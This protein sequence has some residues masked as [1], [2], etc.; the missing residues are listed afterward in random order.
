[1]S[2]KSD[3]FLILDFGSQVTQLIARRLRELNYYSEI[4]SYKTP[5]DEIKKM[6]PKGI[7]LSGG[8][9]SVYEAGAPYRSIKELQEI[10][11]LLGICYG[12][13]LICHDLGGE[14]ESAQHRE[15]GYQ[16]IV[17]HNTF[18]DFSSLQK[19]W[20]SHGDVVKKVPKGFEI[21]GTTENHPAVVK[22]P[23][24]L[25]VQFHPEV[26]HTE[27]GN[28]VFKY[29]A[30]M[31]GAIPS[32]NAGSMLATLKEE[33]LKQVGE[34]SHILCALS[35]GVDS[36]VVATLLTQILG[37][38][39]VHC[40]FVNNGL[41][42]KDE[43]ETV[44]RDFEGL[45][46]NIKG[47]DARNEFLSALKGLTDP[48]Q[49]RK[50]IGRVFIEVFEKTIGN[51]NQFQFLAQGT[52]YPDV[53]E[54]V[55]SIGGSVTI[56]SHHNVGGLP[57]KM[58]L[59]LV[60]PVRLLFKDE[61]RRLGLELGLPAKLIQRHPFPGPGLSIRVIG[62]V[63][64]EKLKILRE[65]DAVFINALREK[66]LYD[67]IWQAFC[68]LLP[69][70]TV[71]VQGD[72]RTYDSVLALRAVTSSDGMTADWYPFD[73]EFMREVSNRITNQV[74]GVSRVVYDVTS[75]PPATIEW[76]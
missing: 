72:G 75:K 31:C 40:V 1:M 38:E 22:G 10:A 74:K 39:R 2:V 14:V 36:S 55:S 6:K 26:A 15:Y 57:E 49:K 18:S 37:A 42:R 27:N 3:G 17:Y 58:K 76:E 45:G 54:S 73:F 4:K 7:I 35:G 8:P 67:K 59:K 30:K 24:I 11:P 5:I 66:N 51:K 71:G 13:Q 19:V 29:F 64:E 70:Q 56:K 25:G 69:V 21:L 63:T 60:E 34:T 50:A 65:A 33:V 9:N 28:D 68:V 12:L 41:L 44:L 16:N 62:E 46:L 48:E 43:Y 52:L 32:W 47:V 53:I 61:V 23:N 20:M